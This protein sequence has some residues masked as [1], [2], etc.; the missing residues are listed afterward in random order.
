MLLIRST[1]TVL[2]LPNIVT[3]VGNRLSHQLRG[4]CSMRAQ[5]SCSFG[6]LLGKAIH[7]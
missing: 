3:S 7:Y 1:I 6:G 2:T 5:S 4:G